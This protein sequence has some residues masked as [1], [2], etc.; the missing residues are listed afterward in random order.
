MPSDNLLNILETHSF[1]PKEV[2]NL[3]REN[4]DNNKCFYCKNTGPN[5]AQLN[6]GRIICTKCAS[7][8]RKNESENIKSLLFDKLEKNQLLRLC[9]FGNTIKKDFQD[10]TL[11]ID[12]I[13]Q[14]IKNIKRSVSKTT[15]IQS[16][17]EKGNPLGS[18]DE[19]DIPLVSKTT[20]IQ[21][22]DEKDN[23][24]DFPDQIRSKKIGSISI[25]TLKNK[26]KVID[27]Q[28]SINSL[29][30]NKSLLRN[31]PSDN[32]SSDNLNK[33]QKSDTIQFIS[34]DRPITKFKYK[35]FD[36]VGLI[37]KESVKKEESNEMS[38]G[39]LKFTKKQQVKSKSEIIKEKGKNI[40]D[41]LL[42]RF[43]RE[44]V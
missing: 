32:K 39:N 22:K 38:Y 41:G 20:E 23:P 1:K 33:E 7:H 15:E 29:S 3:L 42:A 28:S 30:K 17:E 34:L 36:D 43:K 18:K 44:D 16:K 11:L 26:K 14:E 35:G 31:K 8:L 2:L 4:P 40:V 5:C 27:N 6:V 24:S 13:D 12:Q 9:I 37:Q 19:K 10:D 25:E 21:S